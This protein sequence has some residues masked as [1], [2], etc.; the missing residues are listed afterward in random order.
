MQDAIIVHYLQAH[1]RVVTLMDEY[2]CETKR[3]SSQIS[4]ESV[5]EYR[6]GIRYFCD[7]LPICR[8]FFFFIYDIGLRRYTTLLTHFNNHGTEERVHA[9]TGRSTCKKDALTMSDIELIVSF[10]KSHAKKFAIPLPGRM[11]N[12]KN[13]RVVLLPASQN[14]LEVHR[15][16][17]KSVDELRM[18]AMDSGDSAEMPRKPLKIC[19][20][21]AKIC[22]LYCYF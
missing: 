11:A 13:Y 14:K 22:P 21:M 9:S 12:F 3:G 17:K 6:K 18:K 15:Q 5:K 19:R 1:Q 20:F 10:I 2:S 16:Y 7:D 8:A 4:S